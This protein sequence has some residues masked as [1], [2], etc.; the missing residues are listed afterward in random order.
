[1]S[2][3]APDTVSIPE[4]IREKRACIAAFMDAHPEIFSPPTAVGAWSE[5]IEQTEAPDER[6]ERVLDQAT[7]RIVQVIRAAQERT[8]TEVGIQQMLDQA[9]DEGYGEPEADARVLEIAGGPSADDEETAALAR[10]MSLYKDAVKTGL[11]EGNELAQTI[12]AA[13]AGLPAET[14]F[15]QDLL[16]TAKRIVM[17]DLDHAMRPA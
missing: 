16:A 12:E 9:R 7:G 13:F 6:E 5:F 3:L 10:G 4:Y 8:A 14:P 11:A 15:M 1:M 17:I 2:E